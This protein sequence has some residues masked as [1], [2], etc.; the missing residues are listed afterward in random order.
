MAVAFQLWDAIITQVY[1]GGGYVY[2]GNPFIVLL[3]R[4]GMFLPVK[5]FTIAASILLIYLLRRFSQK[6]AASAAASVIV[7][8]A[9]VLIGNYAILFNA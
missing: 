8:Y 2:E 7:L 9:V 4:N 3:F 5:I 1:V 6:I